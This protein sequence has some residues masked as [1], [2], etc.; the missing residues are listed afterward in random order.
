M[1]K[2]KTWEKE[3]MNG[4]SQRKGDWGKRNEHYE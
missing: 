4:Q 3:W 2:N 1:V